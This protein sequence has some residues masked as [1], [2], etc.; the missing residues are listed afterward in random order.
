MTGPAADAPTAPSSRASRSAAAVAG[1]VA[2]GAA[3]GTSELLSGLSGRIPSLVLSVADLLVAET[4]GG[5]V[6]WSI[7]TFGTSQKV[8]LVTGIVVTSLL[9]GAGVG[10]AARSRFARGAAG[11]AG[12]GLLGGWAAARGTLA[13][14][15]WGWLAALV[16]AAAGVAALHLL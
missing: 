9:L 1:L 3:L 15:G 4:P 14:D 5:I 11:F 10:L 12:F 8:V 16:S 7:R 6:R 2:A 13:G